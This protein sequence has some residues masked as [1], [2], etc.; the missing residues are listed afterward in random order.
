MPRAAQGALAAVLIPATAVWIGGLVAIFVVA[1]VAQG[2]LGAVERV[3]FFRG[4]GCVYGLV[5]GIALVVALA[6]GAVLASRHPWNTLATSIMVLV[7]FPVLAAALLVLEIDRRLG[8]RVRRRQRRRDQ[9]AAPVL[10]L[11]PPRGL[12]RGDPVLRHHHRDRAGVL[13]QAAVR[14]RGA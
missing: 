3:A 6:T 9:L 1:R 8:A 12:H 13:P 10:V 14:L 5:G 2:T 4:L 7:A 11:R